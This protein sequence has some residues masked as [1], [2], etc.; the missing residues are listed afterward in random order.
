M[1][2]D[3]Q[4]SVNEL[5]G[6]GQMATGSSSPQ[7]TPEVKVPEQPR[8]LSGC[9]VCDNKPMSPDMS[10]IRLCSYHQKLMFPGSKIG[11]TP[12]VLAEEDEPVS[13]PVWMNQTG[14]L[15]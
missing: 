11:Q 3:I 6:S 10:K 9:D 12:R 14:G 13:T 8:V 4:A 2:T 5:R 1:L 7:P 15:A